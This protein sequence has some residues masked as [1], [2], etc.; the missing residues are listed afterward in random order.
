MYLQ[1]DTCSKVRQNK[2]AL[3]FINECRTED[4]ILDGLVG[5]SVMMMYANQR[6]Y[7]VEDIDFKKNP[8]YEF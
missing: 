5:F 7:I 4:D 2:T 8:K 1:I 6:N 3:D